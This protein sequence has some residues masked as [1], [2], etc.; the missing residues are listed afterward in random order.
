MRIVLP[1]NLHAA[2]VIAAG[3]HSQI[4][5]E[6]ARNRIGIFFGSAR[7]RDVHRLGKRAAH[8][9]IAADIDHHRMH[10]GSHRRVG[11]MVNDVALR[12]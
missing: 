9:Q 1:A 6:D 5:Q 12:E 11:C 8:R 2:P 3:C 7:V 4:M 10:T